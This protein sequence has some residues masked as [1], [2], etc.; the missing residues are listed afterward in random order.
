[1]FVN[2]NRAHPGRMSDDFHVPLMEGCRRVETHYERLNK[3]DE[4]TYGV[5]S[6]ARDMATGEVFA[7]KQVKLPDITAET[8]M[9]GFP[10]TALR[11]IEIMSRFR[12]KNIVQ[13]VEVVSSKGGNIFMVMEYMDHELKDLLENES[14][15]SFAGS[16]IKNLISQLLTGVEFLHKNWIIHRDLKTS[17]L[18]YNNRGELKICDFGLA[19]YYQDPPSVMTRKVVTLWYRSPELLF[20]PHTDLMYGTEIDLWSVGCIFGELVKRRPLFQGSSEIEMAE[21]IFQLV[22]F[23]VDAISKDWRVPNGAKKHTQPQWRSQG[24]GFPSFGGAV[25]LSNKGVDLMSQLLCSDPTTRVSAEEALQHDYFAEIPLPAESMPKFAERSNT[26]H[27]RSKRKNRSDNVEAEHGAQ[28]R[29]E[30]EP[31]RAGSLFAHS[32]VNVDSYLRDLDRGRH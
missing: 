4:G 14:I 15:D 21:L 1:M 32:S 8:E 7:L 9:I 25:S 22:G 3:I 29:E 10:I 13:V 28:M 18:L 17:N 31:K 30:P 2:Y 24:I 12:H 11:E 27:E 5:V 6:R 26:T 19:R 16:E 20:G 23:P